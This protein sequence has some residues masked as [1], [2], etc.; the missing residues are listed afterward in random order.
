MK[1]LP[2][3]LEIFTTQDGS[4]T[5]SWRRSDGYV[6]KMH[7]SGGALE[8]SLYIYHQSLER[9]LASHRP[10]RV[11]SIGLGLGYNELITM[12]EMVKRGLT[13]WQIWSFEAHPDL[14]S[15]FKTW[16]AEG[17]SDSALGL[18]YNNILAR[19]ADRL[20][21]DPTEI[22][23]TAREALHRGTLQLRLSFPDDIS[24]INDVNLIYYDAYSK[25]MDPHLWDEQRLTEKL[26]PLLGERCVLSTY[27]ATGSL[28]RVL[29]HLGFRL[30][31][32]PGFLG[33]RESTLAIRGE[34]I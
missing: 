10:V 19:I 8:E 24:E 32:K 11:M 22:K 27:A 3:N 31:P 18:V 16:I 2:E 23:I 15:E 17:D 21:V 9:V 33:K 28:N 7:H 29:R 6:E 25:K 4:P 14:H 1:P 34:S 26:G 20:K 13:E 30:I 5:L 12:A